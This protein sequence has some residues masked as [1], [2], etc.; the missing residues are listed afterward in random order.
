MANR[1]RP[2][3]GQYS[4]KT[5]RLSKNTCNMLKELSLKTNLTQTSI[6][7]TAM[8]EY[9]INHKNVKAYYER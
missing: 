4:V 5:F 1:G 6:L 3:K 8:R 7:E 9:Y 2:T